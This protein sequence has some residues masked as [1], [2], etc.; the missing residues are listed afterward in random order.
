M[1]EIPKARGAPDDRRALLDLIA[2]K[3]ISQSVSVGAELGIADILKDGPRSTDEIATIAG[4]S[5]DAMF[6]LLR[7][8]ASVGLLS[9]KG[10]RF[11]L[12]ESGQYLRGDVPGSLRGWARFVGHPVTWRPWGELAH[13][14]RTGKPAFDHVFGAPI[15]DYL[16]R[17]PDTA[18]ILNEAMTS[19]STVDAAAVVQAYDFSPVHRLVDVGGG[20][21][22]ML[23]TVLKAHPN[24]RGVLLELPHAIEGASALM[25]REGVAQ[26][27]ELV[28]GDFFRSVPE[29]GDA[30]L[31]KLVIHDWDDDRALQ[32]LRNCQRVMRPKSTLLLVD[33]VLRPGDERDFGKFADLE[34]LVLNAGGR[35][36]TEP[37][38]R[39][40]LAKAGLHLTQ[41][42]PTVTPKSVIEAVRS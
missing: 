11:E 4:T 5:P 15:F 6:R 32:I 26:R 34:M 14:V 40:L 9:S 17:D 21:G 13:S 22:L 28:S 12:T 41:I 20:H 38:F 1:K 31:L 35:E 36:R 37:E 10:R 18:A 42:V 16:A 25:K 27:C 30:Y 2:G 29:G 7:A 8:L 23:A 24:M 3:W 39:D 33:F 19:V